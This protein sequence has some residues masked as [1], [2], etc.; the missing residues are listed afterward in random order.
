MDLLIRGSICSSA[1]GLC[2]SA[3]EFAHGLVYFPDAQTNYI[4]AQR[5]LFL[6]T[7]TLPCTDRFAYS[8]ADTF[9][10]AQINSTHAQRNLR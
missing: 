10:H 2:Q 7:W 3:D 6:S 1:Y 8:W 5:D 4:N 9:S